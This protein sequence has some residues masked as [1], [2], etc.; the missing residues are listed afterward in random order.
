M[1]CGRPFASRPLVQVTFDERLAEQEL[2]GRAIEHV[3]EAVAIAE[4][5]RLA[6]RA[7]PLMSASTGTCDGVVVELVV[8]RELEVP[9][10]LAGVR[11]ERDDRVAVQVVAGTRRRRSSRDPG[12]RCPSRSDSDRDRR[13][14]SPRLSRRRSSTIAGPGLVARLAGT[15]EWCRT[16]TLPCRSS[17]RTRQGT[18]G[19]R[20]RRRRFR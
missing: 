6:R 7:L 9:L 5:H 11:V 16:A 1:F 10:Q 19:C 2:A 12:C 15:G 20:T 14:R 18:R 3:E 4:Q 8:R 17:R 13:S